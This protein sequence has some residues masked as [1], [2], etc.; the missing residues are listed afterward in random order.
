MSADE[1]RLVRAMS[2][3]VIPEVGVGGFG[4]RMSA[5][6]A[7]KAGDILSAAGV[8]QRLGDL[9]RTAADEGET[10]ARMQLDSER[11]NSARS[12]ETRGPWDY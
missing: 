6:D 10:R 11:H 1:E 8:A 2:E 9:L 4:V 3:V 5:A 7:R 12:I